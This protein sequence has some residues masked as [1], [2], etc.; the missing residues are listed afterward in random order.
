MIF[1]WTDIILLPP[2]LFISYQVFKTESSNTAAA[3]I[4]L[5]CCL[6]TEIYADRVQSK[7]TKTQ[8]E[9]IKTLSKR[10]GVIENIF[11]GGV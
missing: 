7:I 3:I 1:K 11:K 8:T 5:L 6:V 10:I 4:M 2:M 9:I